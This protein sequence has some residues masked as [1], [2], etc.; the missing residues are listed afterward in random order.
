MCCFTGPV[1]KVHYTRIFAR[2]ENL[3]RQYV[4]YSMIVLNDREL[5]MVLPLPVRPG[6]DEGAVKF[7]NL[8][9]YPEFFGDL[10]KG[11][12]QPAPTELVF[13]LGMATFSNSLEVVQVGNFEASFVPTVADFARLDKRFRLPEGT[14]EKLPA[15]QRYGFAVFKLAAGHLDVHPMAFSF[16]RADLSNLFFPTVHIHDGQ[17]HEN[18]DFDH[19]LYCQRGGLDKLKLK[20]WAESSAF[21]REFVDVTRAGELIA[22]D[23]HCFRRELRGKLPNRDTVLV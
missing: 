13:S 3:F 23:E 14:W 15:Y 18:A 17:V 12:P 9:N 22:S 16:P 21:A 10:E 1:K 4:V 19:I 20:D 7:I 5:A 8:K 11:F 2:A 6:S